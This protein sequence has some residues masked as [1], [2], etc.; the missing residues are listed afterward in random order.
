MGGKAVA[1]G[2]TTAIFLTVEGIGLLL[3]SANAVKS[4]WRNTRPLWS[5]NYAKIEVIKPHS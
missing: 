3:L 4:T 1:Q 5:G 2:V